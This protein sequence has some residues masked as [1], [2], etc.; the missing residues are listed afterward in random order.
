MLTCFYLAGHL[1]L[2][3]GQV[4]MPVGPATLMEL[5]DSALTLSNERRIH[6]VHIDNPP[7]TIKEL[8]WECDH[9]ATLDVMGRDW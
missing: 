5:S 8:L 9:R 1:M 3:D 7:P 6:R 4:A 2:S